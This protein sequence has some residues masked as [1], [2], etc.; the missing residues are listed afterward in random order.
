MKPLS[1]ILSVTLAFAFFV[2]VQKAHASA[3]TDYVSCWDMDEESGTRFDANTTN[4]NDLS[5]NNTVLFGTGK[6]GN[7]ADFE[8][9][10]AEYLSIT[11]ANQTGLDFTTAGSWS[12]WV[13]L[14]SDTDGVP[15]GKSRTGSQSYF[16]QN[17]VTTVERFSNSAEVAMDVTYTINTG[18]W[19]HMVWVYNAGTATLYVNGSSIGSASNGTALT[20]ST[21]DFRVGM[22]QKYASNYFDGLMDIVEVYDRVLTADEITAIY[23]SG[24]GVACTGRDAVAPTATQ[25]DIIYY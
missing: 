21:A 5:D 18:T 12:Y 17:K 6:I 9:A 1:L 16:I 23:N 2:D 15:M 8:S 25:Q 22:V 4:S 11:D 24:S 7:A 3:P 14:E 20:N 10:N 13:N 19:Y